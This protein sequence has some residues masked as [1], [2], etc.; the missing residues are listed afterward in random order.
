MLYKLRS[1]QHQE[2]FAVAPQPATEA[3]MELDN[4]INIDW[5]SIGVLLKVRVKGSQI[6]LRLYLT[7]ETMNRKRKVESNIFTTLVKQPSYQKISYRCTLILE[8]PD[9]KRL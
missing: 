2:Q 9:P 4:K 8:V 7:N 3:S 1:I 5:G 6:D